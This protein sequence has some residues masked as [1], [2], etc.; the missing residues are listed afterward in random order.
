MKTSRRNF[1]LFSAGAGSSL[2]LS[3]IAFAD[4]SKV[5]EIDPKAQALGYKEIASNVDRSKFPNYKAGQDC[6]NCSLFQGSAKDTYGGCLL[7][8]TQQVA[9]T[10]WCS[11][12]SNM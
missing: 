4:T 6:S 8:G 5:N 7:F 1:L 12:Y 11:S 9:A 10:G 2:A 3:R